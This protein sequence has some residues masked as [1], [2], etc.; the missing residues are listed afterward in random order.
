MRRIRVIPVLLVDSSGG[1]IKT[2]KFGRRTYIGDPINAVK[3][4]NDKGAD[5]LI[6]LDIDATRSGREPNYQLIEDIASEAFMPIGYGG[7]VNR[8]DQVKKL[9]YSGLEKVVVSTVVHERPDFI[10]EASE[11]FGAQ[12]IVVCLDIKKSL[13]GKSYTVSSR[14]GT[15]KLKVDPV[16]HANKVVMLGAGE[17]LLNSI[18]RDGTYAGYDLPFLRSITEAVNIPVV[19]CGGAGSLDDFASA[20]N[21][22]GCSAVA[23][24]S[25]FVY[26]GKQRGV[27]ISYP[28]ESDLRSKLFQKIE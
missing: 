5:E 25:M 21:E 11:Q 1:L 27:L 24:G 10:V 17:L 12:S 2:I 18:D 3:I 15:Q 19:A 6:L 13:F 20:V 23:A 28:T 14:C 9:F 7:G 26:Q 22:A 8:I 16:S 4:F